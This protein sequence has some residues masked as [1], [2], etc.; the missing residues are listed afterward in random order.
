LLFVQIILS[1]AEHHSNIVPWQL[2]AKKTG[3]VLKFAKLTEDERMDVAELKSLITDKTKLVA[4]HHVSNTLGK[5]LILA[6]IFKII[7]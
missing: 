2:I 1:V 6:S 5:L 4:V 3:L 7:F